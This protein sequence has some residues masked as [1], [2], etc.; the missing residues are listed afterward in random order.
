MDRKALGAMIAEEEPSARFGDAENGSYKMDNQYREAEK[1]LSKLSG[2][3][4]GNQK[5]S[6]STL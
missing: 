1:K 4:L 2:P 6:R 5:I 3:Y